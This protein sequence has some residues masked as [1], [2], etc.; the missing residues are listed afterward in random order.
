MTALNAITQ[1]NAQVSSPTRARDPLRLDDIHGATSKSSYLKPGTQPYQVNASSQGLSLPSYDK[2]ISREENPPSPL[3]NRRF[4]N[5]PRGAMVPYATVEESREQQPLYSNQKLQ[6]IREDQRDLVNTMQS[7]YNQ[8]PQAN[9][10]AKDIAN[11]YGVT[12]DVTQNGAF[13]R[14]QQIPPKVAANFY[15]VSPMQSRGNIQDPDLAYQ[16]NAAQFYGVTPNQTVDANVF[17]SQ[18]YNRLQQR[19]EP[20]QDYLK[21]DPVYSKNAALFYG[22]T[23]QQTRSDQLYQKQPSSDNLYAKNAA[24]FYGAT[25]PQSGYPGNRDYN[26]G[27][28]A[29]SYNQTSPNAPSGGTGN[30]YNVAQPQSGYQGTGDYNTNYQAPKYSQT[31]PKIPSKEIANFYGVTPP[32]SGYPGTGNYSSPGQDQTYIK[33]AAKFYGVTPPPTGSHQRESNYLARQQNQQVGNTRSSSLPPRGYPTANTISD[34]EFKLA[35]SK[36]YGVEI[37]PRMANEISFKKNAEVFYGAEMSQG[38]QGPAVN[39]REMQ[40]AAEQFYGISRQATPAQYQNTKYE[41]QGQRNQAP[42]FDQQVYKNQLNNRS[43]LANNA[44]RILG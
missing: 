44:R 42:N 3:L 37:D 23:P 21:N 24:K 7:G 27:Y 1:G 5:K 13:I 40:K 33:N 10:P 14:G 25:P 15:G 2:P 43:T 39:D 36:F 29:Q 12:P 28:Q 20:R 19:N 38:Y 34:A 16:K 30:Y 26:H 8:R 6:T 32:P 17:A 41:Q 18:S 31:S 4:Q 11:F 22:S 35:A 9:L